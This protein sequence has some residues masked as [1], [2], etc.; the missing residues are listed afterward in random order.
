MPSFFVAATP[1]TFL[2]GVGGTATQVE[3]VS[4]RREGPRRLDKKDM[5]AFSKKH[6]STMSPCMFAGGDLVVEPD[7]GLA[8]CYR[9]QPAELGIDALYKKLV[10]VM[11]HVVDYHE[12]NYQP[13][14]FFF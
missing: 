9:G 12:R 8:T 11:E 1:T 7:S 2:Q 4:S 6:A 14:H 10:G 13:R 5:Q 3:A